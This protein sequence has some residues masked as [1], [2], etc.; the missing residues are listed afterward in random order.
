MTR[1]STITLAASPL[2]CNHSA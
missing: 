2:F 1:K